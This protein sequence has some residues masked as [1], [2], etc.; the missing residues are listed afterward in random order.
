MPQLQKSDEKKIFFVKEF[1]MVKNERPKMNENYF[2]PDY[3]NDVSMD[4]LS[5]FLQ[6][7]PENRASAEDL[8][9]ADF[10]QHVKDQVDRWSSG[11]PIFTFE[12]YRIRFN[13][14]MINV[15]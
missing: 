1:G 6:F 2:S 9:N 4:I 14:P 11:M 10:Y 12:E 15:P 7:D 13:T 3:R 8:A 5:C